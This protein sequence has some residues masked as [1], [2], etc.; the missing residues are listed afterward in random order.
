MP[1]AHD[2][3]I[4]L[5][6]ESRDYVVDKATALHKPLPFHKNQIDCVRIL[7]LPKVGCMRLIEGHWLTSTTPINMVELP[8]LVSFRDERDKCVAVFFREIKQRGGDTIVKVVVA[9]SP[10]VYDDNKVIDDS[11]LTAVNLSMINAFE[12]LVNENG[13]SMLTHF[14]CYLAQSAIFTYAKL[15]TAKYIATLIKKADAKKAAHNMFDYLTLQLRKIS[16]TPRAGEKEPRS[17]AGTED[18]NTELQTLDATLA[19]LE[20]DITAWTANI[21]FYQV[22][23]SQRIL[24][25]GPQEDGE[26]DTAFLAR[27][28]KIIA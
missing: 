26:A 17:A 27:C 7:G 19:E 24:H 10:I 11:A 20:E 4:S 14:E 15:K 23:I 21:P 12:P 28:D 1:P 25:A 18:V 6:F 16:Q 5:D 22:P 8:K 3:A 9:R 13:G 2:P